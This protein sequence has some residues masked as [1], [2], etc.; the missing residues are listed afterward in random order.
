MVLHALWMQVSHL[1]GILMMCVMPGPGALRIL[2]DPTKSGGGQSIFCN[3]CPKSG[4]KCDF[5]VWVAHQTTSK[6]STEYKIS[7]D[8]TIDGHGINNKTQ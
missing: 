8:I 6:I 7:E 3:G 5:L 1:D 4:R 2:Y